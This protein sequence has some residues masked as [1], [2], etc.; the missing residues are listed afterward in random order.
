LDST[1]DLLTVALL[2]GVSARTVRQ[3][4]DRGLASACAQPADHADLLSSQARTRLESGQARQDAEAQ[5]A[6]AARLGVRLVG[7]DEADYPGHLR[8]IYDPPPVLWVQG[9]L[10][11][12]EGPRS[13]AIV[14]SRACTPGG[15]AVARTMAAEL[16]AAGATIVSGLARGIDTAAHQGAL[17]ADGR[18]VAVLGSGL[19]CLYPRENTVLARA[20]TSRGA[21]VSE[22]PLGTQARP[23]HFPLRNRLLAGWGCA[24]VVVE[25]AARSG[26]LISAR[27]ALEEGRDVLAVPGPP[28]APHAEGTNALLRDGARLVRS[29]AD[30]AS[31]LGWPELRPVD[32]TRR[33]PGRDALLEALRP[34][35]PASLDEL[36]FR[37]GWPTP[38]LLARLSALELESKIR[39][40][41]GA[42]YVR[43]S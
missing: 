6:A 40:L 28:A 3:L 36:G 5:L 16:A 21:V 17:D 14:G 42:L 10:V 34:D 29:A 30:V 26:A 8:E 19:D 35:A 27:L 1:F 4:S 2:P 20:L 9:T 32:A 31:D 13:L 37:L 7:R 23:H 22:F 11:G 15:A 38:E 25:A 43:A 12:D 33:A 39:R 18:S 41:P 24:V